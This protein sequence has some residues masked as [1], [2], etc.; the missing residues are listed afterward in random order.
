MIK[1]IPC[2]VLVLLTPGMINQWAGTSQATTQPVSEQ[3]GATDTEDGTADLRDAVR[4]LYDAWASGD[5]DKVE[6]AMFV[7]SPEKLVLFRQDAEM[8]RARDAVIAA[9]RESKHDDLVPL[10]AQLALMP[11][12]PPVDEYLP[13]PFEGKPHLWRLFLPP[14]KL[15]EPGS[16]VPPM[17]VLHRALGGWLVNGEYLLPDLERSVAVRRIAQRR[18]RTLGLELFAQSVRDG[19]VTTE[20]GFRIILR[21]DIERASRILGFAYAPPTQAATQPADAVR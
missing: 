21:R 16:G 13:T 4:R 20:N 2:L 5:P 7:I 18:V 6:R 8:I 19:E 12:I 14:E 3:S 15:P 1:L 9:L 11:P 17:F 10:A